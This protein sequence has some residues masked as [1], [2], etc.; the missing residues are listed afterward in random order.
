MPVG[1]KGDETAED[2]E[3]D[4]HPQA[5]PPRPWVTVGPATCDDAS[6]ETEAGD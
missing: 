3:G 5:E 4:R 1:G 2:E 6:Y